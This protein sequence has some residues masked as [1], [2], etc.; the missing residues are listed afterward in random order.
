VRFDWDP[1][2]NELLKKFRSISFEMVVVHLGQGD[3]WKIADHPDQEQ[4]PGQ[5]LFFVIVNGYIHI[6]PHEI[7]GDV[8]W[9][10]TIIPSRKATR[11]YLE[12]SNHE[13]D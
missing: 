1:Q 7:R 8:I 2:K 3:L 11:D 12:E 13:K 10:I 4:Y 6:V 5:S 9:L